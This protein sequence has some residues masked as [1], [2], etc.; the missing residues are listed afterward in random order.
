MKEACDKFKE[1]L[2]Y[3]QNFMQIFVF[4]VN[5]KLSHFKGDSL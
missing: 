3:F 1:D 4:I 2:M 5:Q